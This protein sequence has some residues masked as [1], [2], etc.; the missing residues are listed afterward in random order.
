MKR[1]ILLLVV[2]LALSGIAFANVNG[3]RVNEIC[4]YSFD[5][6]N[7]TAQNDPI[8]EAGVCGNG[9]NSGASTN[10]AGPGG[11]SQAF[12]FSGSGQYVRSNLSSEISLVDG[13]EDV[14]FAIW[15]FIDTI[16][17]NDYLLATSPSGTA[18]RLH[19]FLTDTDIH[20]HVM[21]ENN[22]LQD[23]DSSWVPGF[24]HW[25]HWAV[26]INVTGIFQYTNGT[27]ENSCPKQWDNPVTITDVQEMFIGARN[28]AGSPDNYYDGKADQF[29]V[30]NNSLNSSQLTA[31][32]NGGTVLNRSQWDSAPAAAVGDP[33][34]N[35]SSTIL[36]ASNTQ[37][38]VSNI[39]FNTT[40]NSS[41]NSNCSLVINGTI[42]Q[43]KEVLDNPDQPLNF[44]EILSDGSYE[45]YI[46]CTNGPSVANSS[47]R[48]FHVDT[49][50]P[51]LVTNF[52]NNT[53][54]FISNLTAQFNVTDNLV[55]HSINVSIDGSQ[56]EGIT[57]I[58]SS[59]YSYN[60]SV[61]T[62]N[63]SVGNHTLTFRFA[64]GHT[65][66]ELK[67][68]KDYNPSN[69]LFNNYMKFDFKGEY[70]RTYVKIQNKNS[71]LFDSF[72]ASPEEDRYSITFEPNSLSDTYEFI[73]ESD[74]E[75]F[76]YNSPTY[77]GDWIVFNDH[78]LDFVIPNQK[79]L[80]VNI[81][82]VKK[83]E[84]VV[85]LTGVDS[86]LSRLVFQSIGDL[87]IVTRTY[88]F[89]NSN[90]S[91]T[92]TTP[93]REGSQQTITFEIN[94]SSGI[95]TEA[96]LTWNGSSKTV[97]RTNFSGF[98]RYTANFNT[99]LISSSQVTTPFVWTY[100]IS[101]DSGSEN[102]TIS[103]N[104]NITQLFNASLN[105][106]PFILV[107]NQVFTVNVSIDL[108]VNTTINSVIFNINGTTTVG[109]IINNNNSLA[110]YSASVE[111]PKNFTDRNVTEQINVTINLSTLSGER[112]QIAYDEIQV[113]QMLITTCASGNQ[114][115]LN[116]SFQD[117][118][119]TAALN[120]DIQANFKL[121][122]S[123]AGYKRQSAFTIGST[124]NQPFCVYPHFF[125]GLADIFLE[126]SAT[127]YETRNFAKNSFQITNT[128]QNFTLFLLGT[129][130]ATTIS[131]TVNDE[132]DDGIADVSV[133]ISK[134]NVSDNTYTLVETVVTNFDG[135]QEASLIRGATY[136]FELF[137]EGESKLVK[138][139]KILSSTTELIF[140]ILAASTEVL[141]A[142]IDLLDL[143]SDL[144]YDSTSRLITFTWSDPSALSNEMCLRVNVLNFTAGNSTIGHNCTADISS[145]VLTWSLEASNQTYGALGRARSSSTNLYYTI[146]SLEIDN[147][148][149]K[150]DLG[151]EGILYALV[152]S[153]SIAFL[154]LTFNPVVAIVLF[155]F[156]IFASTLMGLIYLSPATLIAITIGGVIIV[157]YL[158]S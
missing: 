3:L 103:N 121:W 78:W 88:N 105:S 145:G 148:Q 74:Q 97:T 55:L 32:Y 62:Q 150:T 60:L 73:V 35:I 21:G 133:E 9:D 66:T 48:I 76:V 44:S 38:A 54:N 95:T 41:G 139:T 83:N 45:Y 82:R 113:H 5:N 111:A 138:E 53:V 67:S 155:I 136:K 69:G 137:Q 31:L 118:V 102:G 29:V 128:T 104:Q 50:N 126:Y 90:S 131:I 156:G 93:V 157:Y 42:N 149:K 51:G 84:V 134:K 61:N 17:G 13:D 33:G 37:Y 70:E 68:S 92:Y 52:I 75:I 114:T 124:S 27:L 65:A 143:T 58:N 80:E 57:S 132:N 86:K 15:F 142:F 18:N 28:Q 130:N 16:T 146:Q 2:F 72:T 43:T 36:P 106:T 101:S 47:L 79:N 158:K 112:I 6:A 152:F 99:S 151:S 144:V 117:E 12:D 129:A 116:F 25:H 135:K 30:W 85:R 77:K 91:L 10:Q 56:F 87:N 140:K 23:C 147:K 110:T 26:V 14:S 108:D 125:R 107:E 120:V 115:T 153:G 19:P 46:N 59:S 154:G 109:T 7:L 119:S 81:R 8:D 96:S 49:T 89:F 127:N 100:N 22:T 39:T 63:L 64:D 1:V 71:S 123:S 98:N 122:N 40:V 20:T 11:L 34:I 4:H 24:G 141:G 94:T